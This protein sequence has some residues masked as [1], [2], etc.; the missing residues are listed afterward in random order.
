MPIIL[1]VDVS[2]GQV[3]HARGETRRFVPASITK[4][5]TAYVA[6]ELMEAGKLSPRTRLQMAPATWEEWRGKGSTMWLEPEIPVSVG[7]LLTAVTT[8]SANDASVVLAEGLAGSVADWTGLMNEHARK[9]GMVGSHFGTPNGWPDEGRTFT[10][11]EDLVKLA[12]TIIQRHPDRFARYFGKETFTWN[13]I[14]QRNHDPMI[15]VVKGA[16]GIKTGFTNEAGFGFLGT[17][18]RGGQRLVVVVAGAENPAQRNDTARAFIEW[19]FSA[20]D[21][22]RLYGKGDHVGDARVQGGSARRVG[23]VTDRNVFANVP[24]G[25]ATD[26]TAT[27]QYDGPVRAPIKAGERIG[28]LEIIVPGMEPARVPLLAR[29]DVGEAGIFDRLIN[30]LLGWAS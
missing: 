19:G 14:E 10:T 12:R 28:T 5:M 4:T 29:E 16:D 7:T 8:V 27:V 3:L 15:G 11:A 13:D 20:F 17:A 23:L 30:G 6:F 18:Q 24:M 2:S 21:R 22:E 25:R 9:I 26:L 1:L